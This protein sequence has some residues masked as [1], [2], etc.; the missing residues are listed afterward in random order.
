M[1]NKR[2]SLILNN[3]NM[4]HNNCDTYLCRYCS[5]EVCGS[6]PETYATFV[7]CVIVRYVVTT[8][9]TCKS[10]TCIYTVQNKFYRAYTHID[11]HAHAVNIMVLFI[12]NLCFRF[13]I[14]WNGCM[15][16]LP[17]FIVVCSWKMIMAVP[18]QQPAWFA[19]YH[20]EAYANWD[21]MLWEVFYGAKCV[22]FDA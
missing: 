3:G 7:H 1:L 14:A 20:N 15:W 10:G 16:I 6:K 2:Q 17:F 4:G 13:N 21:C 19:M 5:P 12:K 22:A 9:Q 11:P 18:H 8:K